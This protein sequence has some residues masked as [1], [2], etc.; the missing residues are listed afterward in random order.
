MV[1]K[2][3]LELS[4]FRFCIGYLETITEEKW[5]LTP[6]GVWLDS[7]YFLLGEFF[8]VLECELISFQRGDTAE[9]K[10]K[11]LKKARFNQLFLKKAK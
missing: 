6:M 9:L 10:S 7:F 1:S 2:D 3:T 4:F 5:Y 8:F 11:L